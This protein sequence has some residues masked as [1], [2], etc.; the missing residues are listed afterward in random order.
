MGYGQAMKLNDDLLNAI[1]DRDGGR[2][3][4]CGRRRAFHNHAGGGARGSWDVDHGNPVA[5]GGTNRLSNLRVA[6]IPCNRG[7]GA[8]SSRAYRA[9]YRLSPG[10]QQGSGLGELVAVLGAALLIAGLARALN[11]PATAVTGYRA[12][13]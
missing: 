3:H 12:A 5:N 2:C 4:L 10:R 13:S 11:P 6:C 9:T 1:Y 7:K 8:R